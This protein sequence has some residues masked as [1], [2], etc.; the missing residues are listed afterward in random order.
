MTSSVRQGVPP[1]RGSQRAVAG[2]QGVRENEAVVTNET[3]V[4]FWSKYTIA[5]VSLMYHAVNPPSG[6]RGDSARLESQGECSVPSKGRC[7][8]SKGM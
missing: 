6:V 7:S 1:V 5:Q 4:G 8:T 2:A 3:R